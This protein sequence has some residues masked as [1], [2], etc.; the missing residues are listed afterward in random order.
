MRECSRLADVFLDR[1]YDDC[2]LIE[3]SD[4]YFLARKSI[5]FKRAL[6]DTYE[7][8]RGHETSSNT[9]E[10]RILADRRKGG[11][12][13]E[14]KALEDAGIW[15]SLGR[16]DAVYLVAVVMRSTVGNVVY[17]VAVIARSTSSRANVGDG[18]ACC[19]YVASD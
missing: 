10:E 13:K 17:L 5:V 14:W 2:L 3:R 6:K 11:V 1:K 7:E 15:P 16:T 18:S 8:C 9:K 12:G 19:C 4:E